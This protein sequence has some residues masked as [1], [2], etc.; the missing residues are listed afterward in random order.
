[1]NLLSQRKRSFGTTDSDPE[2][3]LGHEG[4]HARQGVCDC[5]EIVDKLPP[6]ASG[7]NSG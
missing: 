6:P 1:M 2:A 5:G 3:N 4:S 7:V